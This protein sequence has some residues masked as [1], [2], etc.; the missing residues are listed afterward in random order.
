M[1][2]L[3]NEIMENKEKNSKLIAEYKGL[4]KKQALHCIQ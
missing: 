1:S 3:V 2:F 4:E